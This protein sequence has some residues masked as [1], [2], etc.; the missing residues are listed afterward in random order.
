[1]KKFLTLLCV[2]CLSCGAF[3]QQKSISFLA[4]GGLGMSNVSNAEA[5]AQFAY[6]V[7]VGADFVIAESGNT[8]IS[9]QPSLNFS[10]KGAKEEILNKTEHLNLQ[11]LD[12]PILLNAKF[13]TG[14]NFDVFV[15][16]GP[17]LAYGLNAKFDDGK[18]LFVK[19]EGMDESMFNPFE[20]GAQIGAGV[21]IN[22]FLVG[23]NTQLGLTKLQQGKLVKDQKA[24]KNSSFFVSLGYRF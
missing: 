4:Q 5:K 9:I 19:Q 23:I 17:Y 16:L 15:N 20:M 22:R 24:S 10:A 12:L 18:N 11:Y 1:M 21:E 2:A 6:R 3:A 13:N 7:G 8:L 14:S